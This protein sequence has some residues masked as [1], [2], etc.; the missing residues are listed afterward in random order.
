MSDFDNIV[1]EIDSPCVSFDTIEDFHSN[2]K[3]NFVLAGFRGI[4]EKTSSEGWYVL[5]LLLLD[6]QHTYRRVGIVT[7]H[8]SYQPEAMEWEQFFQNVAPTVITIM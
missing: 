6:D 2:A 5:V 4:H 1:E 7:D 3:N 8:R